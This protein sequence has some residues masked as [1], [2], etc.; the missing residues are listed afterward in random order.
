[1]PEA[2]VDVVH[3][4]QRWRRRVVDDGVAGF[5]AHR[6]AW[7]RVV[8]VTGGGCRS[9]R[10]PP[11]LRRRE[12]AGLHHALQIELGVARVLGQTGAQRFDGAHDAYAAPSVCWP[13]RQLHGQSS[14][15]CS[16]SSARITSSTLR[17]TERSLAL[18]QRMIPFGSTMKVTRI[19]APASG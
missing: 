11:P 1:M 16:A 8:A 4:H 18:T 15:L 7:Y 6:R 19:A 13:G 10:H 3:G 9:D 12:R 5:A 14:S 17:P 2:V